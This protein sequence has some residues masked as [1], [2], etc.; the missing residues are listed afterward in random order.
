M[1]QLF[2]LLADR[3]VGTNISGL[4]GGASQSVSA[5]QYNYILEKLKNAE[6]TISDLNSQVEA[7][8]RNAKAFARDFDKLLKDFNREVNTKF[9]ISD[10]V[11][12]DNRPLSQTAT[13]WHF[14]TA[15]LRAYVKS[16]GLDPK[17]SVNV[18]QDQMTPQQRYTA[19]VYLIAS[20]DYM[21]LQNHIVNVMV[22]VGKMIED[23]ESGN[24][25]ILQ[26]IP[27]YPDNLYVIYDSLKDDLITMTRADVSFF[28]QWF[29]ERVDQIARSAK[30]IHGTRDIDPSTIPDLISVDNKKLLSSS[31]QLNVLR[32]KIAP[33]AQPFINVDD[34]GR[35]FPSSYASNAYDV[36]SLMMKI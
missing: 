27:G 22:A 35:L 15:R 1:N 23:A 30:F 5:E 11:G 29:P 8:S 13:A 17:S 33:E 12:S 34:Q 18:L 36:K 26:G 4:N 28:K 7:E 16:I 21:V 24:D 25:E 10:E 14:I 32:S 31:A 20:A 6:K 3:M 9:K 2:Q 19:N